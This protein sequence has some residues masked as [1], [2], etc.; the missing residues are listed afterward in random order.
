MRTFQQ[1]L[2]FQMLATLCDLDWSLPHYLPP[3]T[4]HT[5]TTVDSGRYGLQF[6]REG[7]T[8]TERGKC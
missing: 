7:P 3:R 8:P 5:Y 1:T 6:W 2:L 4:Q